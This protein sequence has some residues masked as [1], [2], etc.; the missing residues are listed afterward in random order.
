MNHLLR[1][2][3]TIVFCIFLL[4]VGAFAQNRTV[5][6]KVTSTTDGQAMPGVNVTLKGASSGSTTDTEGN[7]R[8]NIPAGKVTLVFSFVGMLSQEVIVNNRTTINVELV[9][10][11]TQLNE[12]VVTGYNSAQKKDILG[13]I[14]S[15]SAAKFK[16]IPIAGFDQ[17]LQGQAAGVQVT[18][19]SGTPGGGVAVR[20]RGNTSI[21]AS[22]RP[23]FVVDGIP[24][25][26]DAVSG[27]SFGGQ[28]DNTLTFVNPNDIESIQVLKDASAKAIYGSR[29]ANGVVLIT[30]KRG[31]ANSRTNITLDAQR[32][33][34]DIIKKVDMLSATELLQLQ[35]EA[36]TNAGQDPDQRGLIPGVTDG[37]N[38]DWL[39]AI[40]RRG[41]YQQYQ[42]S[43][44][45]GNDKTRF[46]L[47]GGL[48]DEQGVQLN[49]RFTRYSG[50]LNVDHKASQKLTIST[51]LSLGFTTNDRVKGDNFLD[52]V[53]SGAIKS[54]PYFAPY[55]EQ[56]KL[57]TPG[58][59]NY[60]G[61]PNFNPV[62][63]AVLPRFRT[64]GTKILAGVSGQYEI[65]KNLKLNSK[66]SLDYNN[67]EEDQY[68]SSATAIGGFLPAI[69][70]QGYGVYITNTLFTLLNS[71]TL[72]YLFDLGGKHHFNTM[73]GTEILQ[74][75]NR[76]SFASGRIF[77]SDDFT[78]INS[79]GVQDAAGS[80]FAQ[81]GLISG[82]GEVRYDYMEKYL[83]TF[84]SRYDGSSRFGPNRR[85]GYFPSLSLGWR[86]SEEPWMKSL[87]FIQDLKLRGSY[88]YTGNERIG[89]FTYLGTWAA[90]TYSGATGVSPNNLNN[91]LLQWERTREANV[92]LDISL[93]SGRLSVIMEA[94]DNL[95]DNLLFNQP[96]PLTTGFG[97]FQG[98][99]GSISNRGL[100]LT[101]S[102]VN[103]DRSA[104]QGLRW[105]TDFNI[106]HNENK[107]LELVD[108][109][110]LFRGYTANGVSATN[111]ILPGQPLG[112]FWGLKFQGVDVATGNALYEDYN[113]DGRIS[114][115]DAQVIGNAQPLLVGGLTNRVTWGNFDLSVFF[116]FMYGNKI[117]NFS[118]VTLLDNGANLE[119]NQV[120][121]ALRRWQKPGDVTDVPR[122]ELGNTFNNY[123]SSR[124][125]EDGSYLRLK[126]VAVGY[127]FPS[128]WLNK[129][130][131]RTA[132]LYASA[133]NLWTLTAYSGADPEVSTLDGS[134]SAQ[135]IDFFTLPQTRNITL[136]LT[137]GF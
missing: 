133:V 90:S 111:V 98:N 48:R 62:A 117:L 18:Q 4:G 100:E 34:V 123:H 107:V 112:T 19:S 9:E 81:N 121:A 25:M 104:T 16:D 43:A 110:P 12:V 119:N 32:G 3:F 115:D 40:L 80:S 57:Y 85:F 99:I 15:V 53:Y 109:Q 106:S 95:T 124:F 120:R 73:I 6:G 45:G 56:G 76:G 24:V 10:S 126:N 66:L 26:D 130:K 69:G 88:G 93:W 83:L 92:G 37:V 33:V 136:G 79:S 5:T 70:G 28:N 30:T 36:V 22:N 102:T 134:T 21:S 114:P 96:L 27:R 39:G 82:F 31:K 97:G 129:V 64:Y 49:N 35:R 65:I 77:P 101:L 29:A 103:I 38:T 128:R 132:R 113:K 11:P 42:A 51:N 61:F 87:D 67:S 94:Y 78:Y 50:A 59:P 60:A 105:N 20:I 137:I 68:E 71:N 14:T 55:N 23:L 72:T 74:T 7:Y 8:I 2:S 17:A 91:P 75:K 127:N 1:K 13:S 125:L 52:G 86:I 108:N 135:G 118:N 44:T 116:Q 89:N 54:L 46:Y 58:N 47:S 41:I 122:Y 84:T 131:I 63:Q